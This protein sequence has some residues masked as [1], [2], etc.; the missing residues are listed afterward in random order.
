MRVV[1]VVDNNGALVGAGLCKKGSKLLKME[2]FGLLLLDQEG[3][4]LDI[5]WYGGL[6]LLAYHNP[7]VVDDIQGLLVIVVGIS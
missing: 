7:G 3:V 6:V 4:V 5:F 1:P 2:L